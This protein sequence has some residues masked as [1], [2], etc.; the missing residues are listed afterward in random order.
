MV[1]NIC[2]YLDKNPERREELKESIM[3]AISLPWEAIYV[4]CDDVSAASYIEELRA[5]K[6]ANGTLKIVPSFGRKHVKDILFY[7][8]AMSDSPNNINVIHNTDISLT[9]DAF[10]TIKNLSWKEYPK[11]LL[12]LSRWDKHQD[13]SIALLDRPDSADT[14]VFYSHAPSTINVPCYLGTP[15][16]DNRIAAEF[17]AAGYDVVNPSRDIKTIHSH[18]V[19]GNN[20][21]DENGVIKA[22]QLCAEP[23]YFHRPVFLK[24]TKIGKH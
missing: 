13:G 11:T 24:D 8:W 12:A 23:Y 14:W 9:P 4:F 17:H 10:D 15:G 16:V 6:V 7:S 5:D 21:R 19:L 18:L 20:Y 1:L 2:W 22:S 3:S